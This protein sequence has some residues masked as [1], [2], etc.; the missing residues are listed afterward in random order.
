MKSLWNCT[1]KVGGLSVPVKLYSATRQSNPPFEL[2]DSR[3]M[4]KIRVLKLNKDTGEPVPGENIGKAYNLNGSLVPVT[5]DLIRS[6]IPE[7][8]SILDFSYFVYLYDIPPVC[9]DNFYY[10][11]PE[12]SVVSS[13]VYFSHLLSKLEEFDLAGLTQV[14][15]RNLSH[16]FAL[17][18]FSNTLIL[19]K[20][21]FDTQFIPFEQPVLPKAVTFAASFMDSFDAFLSDHTRVFNVLD[22]KD[23]FTDNLRSAISNSQTS[24][25]NLG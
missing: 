7:K 14:V 23:T 15:F 20:L 13:P 17:S 8:N 11:L 4:S 9:F 24:S 5:N 10:L 3:S 1:L 22:F 19:Y 12:E 25:A 6:C 21:R 18:H 16:L 2:V